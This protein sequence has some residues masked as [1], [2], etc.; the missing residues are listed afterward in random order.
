MASMAAVPDP[1][2]SASS[3]SEATPATWNS[4]PGGAVP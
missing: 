1:A 4:E 2:M 3:Q